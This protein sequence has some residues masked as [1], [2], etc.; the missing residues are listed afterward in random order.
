MKSEVKNIL[1]NTMK[2]IVLEAVKEVDV[3]GIMINQVKSVTESIARD[4]FSNYGD[5]SKELE[6]KLKK[7]ISFNI[8]RISVPNFG[9]IAIG[10]VK[11][12]L[13]NIEIEQKEKLEKRTSKRLRQLL[14]NGKENITCTEIENMFA[15]V[16][17]SKIEYY[18]NDD[19]SC[20]DR[21]S[22]ST[23]EDLKEIG[24]YYL[25]DFEITSTLEEK[26]M[27]WSASWNACTSHLILQAKYNGKIIYNI[28]I[29]LDRQRDKEA[30]E[31]YTDDDYFMDGRKN[32]Y[33]ILSVEVNGKRFE[34]D[35]TVFLTRASNNLEQILLSSY[36]NGVKLDMNI[37]NYTEIESD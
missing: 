4:I 31:D 32:I 36:L 26:S 29:H 11:A 12:E 37:K 7:E 5:F 8:D 2:D 33:K 21:P 30:G 19:C 28:S 13:H 35:G 17:Y 18:L 34:E 25:N 22:V 15:Q 16:I 6:K 23:F 20:G 1:E 14:G 10:T 3:K 9:E 24:E 27:N